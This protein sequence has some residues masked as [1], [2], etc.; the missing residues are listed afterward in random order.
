MTRQEIIAAILACKEK[1]G[2]VPTRTE[3]TKHGNVRREQIRVKFSSFTQA[4]RECNLERQG[5]KEVK[6]DVLFKEWAGIVRK[7]KKLPTVFEY[8][9]LSQ[10]SQKP[11]IR[12]FGMWSNAPAGLKRWAEEN[13]EA[14]G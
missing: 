12:K 6:L 3:L 9:Q 8:E 4:L 1:L 7:L 2:R 10:F 11:L 14:A 5:P 13:G